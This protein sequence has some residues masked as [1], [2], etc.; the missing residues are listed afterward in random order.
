M[1]GVPAVL[2][3]HYCM[4]KLRSRDAVTPLLSMSMEQSATKSV[5]RAAANPYPSSMTALAYFNGRAPNGNGNVNV[6]VKV[7]IHS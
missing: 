4:Y 5:N 7:S 2:N 1:T 6:N 3:W